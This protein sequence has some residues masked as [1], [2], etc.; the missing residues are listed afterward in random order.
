VAEVLVEDDLEG[1]VK[2]AAPPSDGSLGVGR[3][4]DAAAACTVYFLSGAT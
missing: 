4:L 2:R 1:D 3:A